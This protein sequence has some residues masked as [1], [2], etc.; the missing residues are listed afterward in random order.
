MSNFYIKK[1]SIFG[2]DKTPSYVDFE[3]GLN[4][5]HGVSD[6]G[7]TCIVKCIDFV[8]GSSNNT[9]IPVSHGYDLVKLLIET[10][11]GNITLERIIGKN[12]I[13]LIS[14]DIDFDNGEYTLS[15]IG[16]VLLPLIGIKN[17]PLIIKNSRYEKRRLTWRTFMHS[18]VINEE[19]IIKTPP[20]L[21]ST[22]ST[23]KTA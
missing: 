8:F 5:I 6:T 20:I 2:Q 14:S 15:E 18:F 3:K 7:K 13:K 1:L 16:D 10:E 22:E 21:I 12:K 23:A 4:I 19:E 17:K 11:N 9:P